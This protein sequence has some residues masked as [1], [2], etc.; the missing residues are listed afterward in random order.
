MVFSWR[1]MLKFLL[2]VTL[3]GLVVLYVGSNRQRLLESILTLNPGAATSG[4]ELPGS[5]QSQDTTAGEPISSTA[6]AASANGSDAQA[7]ILALSTFGEGGPDGSSQA[8][9]AGGSDVFIEFRLEREQA[10]SLQLDLLREILN[11]ANLGGEAREE[12]TALWLKIVGDV[13]A[14]VDLENLIRAKGF[15]DAVVVLRAGKA[16]IMVK[17]ASLTREEALRIADLAIRVAGISFEDV[18]VMARGG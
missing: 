2:F 5:P 8:P 12:A 1:E 7:E 15:A 18:T 16:T 6:D 10:R 11:N 4:A 3:I 14:E 13:A 9:T 17:A